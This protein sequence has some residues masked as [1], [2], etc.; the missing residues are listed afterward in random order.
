[1]T[2]LFTKKI[3]CFLVFFSINITA[4]SC[5]IIS[6][7]Q[8]LADKNRLHQAFLQRPALET[9]LPYLRYLVS[10]LENHQFKQLLEGHICECPAGAFMNT[11][12]S[13]LTLSNLI[14]DEIKLLCDIFIKDFGGKLRL[15]EYDHGKKAL[16]KLA[17]KAYCES[18]F[19]QALHYIEPIQSNYP[20]WIEK[21][22]ILGKMEERLFNPWQSVDEQLVLSL[23]FNVYSIMS[24]RLTQGP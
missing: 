23:N 9:T 18:Q 12:V 19:K 7:K 4:F 17:Y 6:F 24:W 16:F 20:K 1:M 2:Y 11:H 22:N 10:F 3:L 8:E 5:E 14:L 15:A 13:K 21:L